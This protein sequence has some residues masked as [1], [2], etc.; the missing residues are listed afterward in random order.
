M[1]RIIGEQVIELLDSNPDYDQLPEGQALAYRL[2]MMIGEG[3][4][5]EQAIVTQLGLKSALPLRSR[6]EHLEERGLIR[7]MASAVAS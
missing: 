6:L 5:S 2:L 7:V 3:P 1:K 4:Y